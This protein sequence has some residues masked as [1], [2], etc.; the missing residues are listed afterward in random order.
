MCIVPVHALVRLSVHCP[1]STDAVGD[2]S[3]VTRIQSLSQEK[4]RAFDASTAAETDSQTH[5]CTQARTHPHTWG[6]VFSLVVPFNE[7]GVKGPEESTVWIFQIF[8]G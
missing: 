7:E 1:G 3:A 5:S 8:L 6:L 2:V 4:H